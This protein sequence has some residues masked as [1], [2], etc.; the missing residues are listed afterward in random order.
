M[1]ASVF[2]ETF[3]SALEQQELLDITSTSAGLLLCVCQHFST[4]PKTQ[5]FNNH[6]RQGDVANVGDAAAKTGA[7][8]GRGLESAGQS[9][10][11][12]TGA[13]LKDEGKGFQDRK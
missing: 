11:G 2:A 8:V 10:G 4:P 6:C 12:R 5:H 3:G 13:G 7:S 9:V 1:P